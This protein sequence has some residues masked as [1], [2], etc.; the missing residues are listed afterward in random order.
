MELCGRSRAGSI[1]RAGAY[2]AWRE[3]DDACKDAARDRIEGI[4]HR[5]SGLYERAVTIERIANYASLSTELKGRAL[6]RLLIAVV[7]ASLG[8]VSFAWAANPPDAD[9]FPPSLRNADLRGAA[10]Q[11]SNLRGADLTGANLTG[12]NLSGANLKDANTK[13]VTWS[14]TVCPDGTNSDS[15]A[16]PDPKSGQPVGGTCE[17]HLVL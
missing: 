11:G 2:A 13:D 16:R 7:V 15:V 12:A 5:I 6:K 4:D 8:I 3:A 9:R 1:K 17:G 14:H 10:L